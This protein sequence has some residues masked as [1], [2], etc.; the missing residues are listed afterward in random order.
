MKGTVGQEKKL[1]TSANVFNKH[2]LNGRVYAK[3]CDY[4]SDQDL[5]LLSQVSECSGKAR[6]DKA[7][8]LQCAPK[9]A[10]GGVYSRT[11]NTVWGGQ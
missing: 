7:I 9:G 11:P 5:S 4:N 10:N 1:E 2:L 3:L 8:I 6:E